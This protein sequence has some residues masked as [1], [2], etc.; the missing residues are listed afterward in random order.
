MISALKLALLLMLVRWAEQS[1]TGP[2]QWLAE[3]LSGGLVFDVV[4][5]TTVFSLLL[6]LVPLRL[7]S[8]PLWLA[9]VPLRR[10]E[11]PR[12]RPFS[13][14]GLAYHLRIRSSRFFLATI[15][16]LWLLS[17]FWT[18]LSK[19]VNPFSISDG[20]LFHYTALGLGDWRDVL[21]DLVCV[22]VLAALGV[23]LSQRFIDSWLS[24]GAPSFGFARYHVLRRPVR[25]FS[26]YQLLGVHL[27]GCLGLAVAV[28]ESFALTLA[29][30]SLLA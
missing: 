16:E 3:R 9:R 30:S 12:R 28:G 8:L 19:Q 17:A 24:Q 26:R 14:R 5:M 10:D 23:W 25:R 11:T 13:R 29:L 4:N 22:H 15:F 6:I 18:I 20:L 27:A 1:F 21:I 7:L 2:T